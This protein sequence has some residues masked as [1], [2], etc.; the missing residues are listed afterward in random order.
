MALSDGLEFESDLF[1]ATFATVDAVVG[2]R[3][4]LENGPG[5]ADFGVPT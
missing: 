1:C 2:V 4:F 5:N 3:S